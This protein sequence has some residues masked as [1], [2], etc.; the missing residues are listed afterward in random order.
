MNTWTKES[1]A[2]YLASSHH[3]TAVSYSVI[4][5]LEH[6]LNTAACAYSVADTT[7]FLWKATTCLVPVMCWDFTF[8]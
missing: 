2:S 1:F 7:F 5:G 6:T 8:T 4:I 3:Q